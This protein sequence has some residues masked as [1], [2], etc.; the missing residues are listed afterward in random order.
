MPT[1]HQEHKA[2][3]T[4]LAGMKSLQGVKYWEA[5]VTEAEQIVLEQRQ[6]AVEDTIFKINHWMRMDND[7]AVVYKEQWEAFLKTLS[8]TPEKEEDAT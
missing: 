2:V 5:I 4:Q 1:D 6:K 8:P 3:S 7:V